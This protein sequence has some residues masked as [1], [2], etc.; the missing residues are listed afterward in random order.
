[1][2]LKFDLDKFVARNQAHAAELIDGWIVECREG[3]SDHGSQAETMAA[4]WGLD[5]S[6]TVARFAEARRLRDDAKPKPEAEPKP[7]PFNFRRLGP[8]KTEPP[9]GGF[10]KAEEQPQVEDSPETPKS[11]KA[12]SILDTPVEKIGPKGID[13]ETVL[14]TSG[15]TLKEQ[16]WHRG[17]TIDVAKELERNP[18]PLPPPGTS[19]IDALTYPKGLLGHAVQVIYDSAPLFPDRWMSLGG[20]LSALAKGLDRKVLGPM[21]N[22]TVLFIVILGTVGAG[23][24]HILNAVRALLRAMGH[25]VLVAAGDIASIQSIREAIG[26]IKGDGEDALP[27]VLVIMDEYGSILNRITSQGAGGGNVSEIPSTLASLWGWPPHEEYQGAM[28][29]GTKVVTVYGPAFAVIGATTERAYFRAFKKPQVG[30]GFA[31]RQGIF[32]AGRDGRGAMKRV[33]RKYSLS[34][35]SGPQADEYLRWFSKMLRQ[36]AGPIAPFYNLPK[37]DADGVVQ[38]DWWR[39]G[40][41]DGALAIWDAYLEK[42]REMPSEND[43]DHW[44]RA[45]EMGLRYATVYAPYCGSPAVEV[46]HVQWGIDLAHHST[47]Q[48]A[49]GLTKYQHEEYTQSELADLIRD[50]YVSRGAVAASGDEQWRVMNAG[51]LK[52]ICERNTKDFRMIDTVIK[53]LI[54]VGDH[55]RI[56][57]PEWLDTRGRKTT[58]YQWL[59]PRGWRRQHANQKPS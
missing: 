39:I 44:I 48:L 31:S 50:A 7:P 9:Q 6:E 35:F 54:D 4:I 34:D 18:A 53:H 24:Q 40:W 52:D 15:K 59:R 8:T 46:E 12:G 14:R 23:K 19:K 33:P 29:A 45:P 28:K 10:K 57:K 20:A 1:M 43:L 32:K 22:S 49:W 41:G 2:V 3:K 37:I 30:G 58:Y 42:V 17:V 21:D 5:V 11:A 16:K 25:Q 26:G 56:P 27:S 38:R 51:E 36:V 55:E 47:Q 13:A